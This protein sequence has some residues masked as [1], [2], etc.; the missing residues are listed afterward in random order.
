MPD[1]DLHINGFQQRQ[2]ELR[3]NSLHSTS[4]VPVGRRC[5]NDAGIV[6]L[7]PLGQGVGVIPLL[8]ITHLITDSH[9]RHAGWQHVQVTRRIHLKNSQ[10]TLGCPEWH[11]GCNPVDQGLAVISHA[12]LIRL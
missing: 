6:V 1:R 3:I 2:L 10:F 9:L 8:D 12:R 4:V 11:C 5:V 7:T